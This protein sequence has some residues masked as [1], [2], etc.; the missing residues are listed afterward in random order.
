MGLKNDDVIAAAVSGFV[1]P[2]DHFREKSVRN[3]RNNDA[4][5]MAFVFAQAKGNRVWGIVYR[6]GVFQDFLL[7]ARTD[8]ITVAKCPG[9]RRGRQV[10]RFGYILD[11]WFKHNPSGGD[12]NRLVFAVCPREINQLNMAKATRI[13]KSTHLFINRSI[14]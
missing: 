3:L 14:P 7:G 11:G 12:R 1:N 5:R 4:N 13:A 10:Q 2:I 6:L 9:N 8:L